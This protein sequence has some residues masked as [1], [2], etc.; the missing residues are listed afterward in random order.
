[1]YQRSHLKIPPSS[2]ARERRLDG[3]ETGE[4]GEKKREGEEE[5]ERERE[6]EREKELFHRTEQFDY[7]VIESAVDRAVAPEE[8]VDY[9]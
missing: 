4:P 9:N 2:L 1:M 8:Y 5:R 7:R 3:A 6:R